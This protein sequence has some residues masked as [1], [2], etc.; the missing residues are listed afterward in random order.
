MPGVRRLSEETTAVLHTN[1]GDLRIP[2]SV[3]LGFYYGSIVGFSAAAYVLD[4]PVGAVKVLGFGIVSAI[5]MDQVAGS[6]QPPQAT[7]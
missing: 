5:I 6:E 1:R 3:V 2:G 4:G 7:Q